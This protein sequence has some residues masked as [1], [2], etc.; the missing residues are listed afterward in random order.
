MKIIKESEKRKKCPG[1][2][3]WMYESLLSPSKY[4]IFCHIKNDEDIDSTNEERILILELAMSEL[5]KRNNLLRK[6]VVSS[7]YR[8]MRKGWKKDNKI[9]DVISLLRTIV[10]Q[11]KRINPDD[12]I[13]GLREK[14]QKLE[15][16][17]EV[18]KDYR[19][20]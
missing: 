13:W 3:R 11:L 19:Y 20:D 12:I 4:C 6:W 16:V 17:E 8:S 5:V 14:I 1:C 7:N 10:E 2:H 18:L 9:R 15:K